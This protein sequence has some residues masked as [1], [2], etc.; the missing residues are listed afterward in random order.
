LVGLDRRVQVGDRDADVVDPASA[1]AR[2]GT[3]RLPC[4]DRGG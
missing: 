3:G 4:K 2:D 1:Q